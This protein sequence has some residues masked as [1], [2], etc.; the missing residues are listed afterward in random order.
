ME[1]AHV[2]RRPGRPRAGSEDKRARILVEAL[3]VFGEKGYEGASLATIARA[4]DITKPGLLHHF[5]SKEEL[6]TAVLDERDRRAVSLGVFDGDRS[7]RE[8]LDAFCALVASNVEEIE[9]TALFTA[10][11]GAVVTA[12]HPAHAW[13]ADHLAR[14]VTVL[15]RAFEHGKAEGVL[16]PDAPS[17]ELARALVA[18]SDGLQVQMLCARADR[19]AQKEKPGSEAAGGAPAGAEGAPTPAS[20]GSGAVEEPPLDGL[21]Y[22]TGIAAEFRAAAD[23]L[24]ATWLVEDAG[25]GGAQG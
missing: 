6:F 22:D 8:V 19:R 12:D 3:K 15:A 14:A 13:F 18:L 10:M 11:T 4:A 9:G 24:V 25:S 5:G 2:D 21:P 1:T 17:W 16:R 23:A 20:P 7:M